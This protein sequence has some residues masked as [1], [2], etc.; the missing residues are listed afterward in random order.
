MRIGGLLDPRELWEASYAA[1]T[2]RLAEAGSK[3]RNERGSL[4]GG[5][6]KRIACRA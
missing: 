4:R 1:I 6:F 2:K 3:A 5:D